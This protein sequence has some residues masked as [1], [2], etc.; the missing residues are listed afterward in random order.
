MTIREVG[1]DRFVAPFFL[2]GAQIY[3]SAVWPWL[4]F[5]G[6]W[7]DFLGWVRW[8]RPSPACSGQVQ[9]AWR[10]ERAELEARLLVTE[11]LVA[12]RSGVATAHLD[13]LAPSSEDPGMNP[14][15]FSCFALIYD[16]LRLPIPAPSY[17]AIVLQIVSKLLRFVNKYWNHGKI[18]G[19]KAPSPLSTSE[20]ALSLP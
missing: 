18:K 8:H 9:Q 17:V 14:A 13:S 10:S 3:V 16:N 1:R 2:S 15:A 5:M 6:Y 7:W 19:T 12:G 11:L 20:M 4:D